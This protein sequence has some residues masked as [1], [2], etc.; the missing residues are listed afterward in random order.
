MG[1]KKERPLRGGHGWPVSSVYCSQCMAQQALSKSAEGIITSVFDFTSV[2]NV[3]IARTL[4]E[5]SGS[6]FSYL[7]AYFSAHTQGPLAAPHRAFPPGQGARPVPAPRSRHPGHFAADPLRPWLT[8]SGLPGAPRCG[9]AGP[10][11]ASEGCQNVWTARESGWTGVPPPSPP[12]P[13]G[14]PADS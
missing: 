6:N 1:W 8:A 13:P 4:L 10:G 5:P 11:S 2:L 9:G 12:G 3:F 7:T 14:N